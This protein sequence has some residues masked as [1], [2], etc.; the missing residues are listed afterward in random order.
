MSLLLASALAVATPMPDPPAQDDPPAQTDTQAI[1][2]MIA[3]VDEEERAP[4]EPETDW[5][6]PDPFEPLNRLLYGLTQPI[7]ALILR[8]AALFYQAVL[9]KPVR[10]GVHNALDNIFTPTV[11]ANDIL[12]LRPRRAGKTLARFVIN[13]TLGVGGLFDVA[14]RK[15]FNIAGHPN[16]LSDTLGVAGM[17]DGAYLYLP[18]IGPTNLRDLVGL[19]GDAFTQPMLLNRVYHQQVTTVNRRKRTLITS[20]LTVSNVGFATLTLGGLD[21]RARADDEL[22]AFKKQSVDPYAALR[23]TYLQNRAGQIARAKAKDGQDTILPALDDPLTDPAQPA[24]R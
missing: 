19:I 3:K 16:G 18:L 6:N 24:A 11:L 12:Q 5:S 1:D 15:P 8:P 7:D 17:E 22:Q 23:S 4:K 14:R 9:P 13:S 21:T 20:T 2:A 10:D